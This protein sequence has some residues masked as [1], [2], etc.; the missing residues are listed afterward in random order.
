MIFES[1][2]DLYVNRQ[3][4][5]FV[6]ITI[7]SFSGEKLNKTLSLHNHFLLYLRSNWQLENV[8]NPQNACKKYKKQGLID[9]REIYL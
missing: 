8:R 1:L 7:W 6:C 5:L 9:L 2:S 4:F 3:T